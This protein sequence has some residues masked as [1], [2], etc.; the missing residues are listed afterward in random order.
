MTALMQV[1]FETIEGQYPVQEWEQKLE[2]LSGKFRELK[3][4]GKTIL[5][6]ANPFANKSWN[7]PKFS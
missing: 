2:K 3:E 6:N 4:K 7:P 5:A 1:Y